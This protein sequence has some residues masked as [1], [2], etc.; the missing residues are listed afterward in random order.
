MCY[1]TIRG[2]RCNHQEPS[3]AE[4]QLKK[5]QEIPLFHLPRRGGE[6]RGGTLLR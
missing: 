5:N 3:A 4:P 1:E 2:K 6:K